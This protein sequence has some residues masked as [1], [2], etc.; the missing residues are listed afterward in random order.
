M[1]LGVRGAAPSDF[2]SGDW[3]RM[4]RARNYLASELPNI[5][6]AFWMAGAER[7]ARERGCGGVRARDILGSL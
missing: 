4:G 3:R 2:F 5:A 6:E 1:F 7:R